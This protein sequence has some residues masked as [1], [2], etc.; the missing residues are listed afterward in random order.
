MNLIKC[1]I[2]GKKKYLLLFNVYLQALIKLMS[3]GISENKSNVSK[4]RLIKIK[5]INPKC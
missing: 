4:I 2:F 1:I 3:L 5:F